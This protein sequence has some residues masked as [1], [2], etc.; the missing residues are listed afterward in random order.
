MLIFT[1]D[2]DIR[3]DHCK[4]LEAELSAKLGQECAVIPLCNG[5]LHVPTEA[6]Q[7]TPAQDEYERLLLLQPMRDFAI[8][9]LSGQNCNAQETA[10][11]PQ[12]LSLL[13]RSKNLSE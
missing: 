6:K 5:A 9:V 8:R 13:L 1:Y 7:S 10:I 4:T 3:A 12:I 11:L 2:G